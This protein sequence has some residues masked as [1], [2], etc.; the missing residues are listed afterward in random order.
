MRVKLGELYTD[1][2]TGFKGVAVGI[3]EWL[4]QCR[5]VGLQDVKLT[6]NG[7]P[8]ALQWFDEPGLIDADG[9]PVEDETAKTGGPPVG[10]VETG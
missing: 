5:R 7:K 9:E 4:H 10:R 3:T 2:I 6:E 8:L 1:E